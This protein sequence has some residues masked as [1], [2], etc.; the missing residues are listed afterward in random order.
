MRRITWFKNLRGDG[1][2]RFGVT[3]GEVRAPEPGVVRGEPMVLHLFRPGRDLSNPALRWFLDIE[4]EGDALPTQPEDVRGW[5]AARTDAM[6]AG[7]CG[8]AAELEPAGLD[9]GPFPLRRSLSGNGTECPMAVGIGAA[10][11][12]DAREVGRLL[13][14]TASELPHVLQSLQVRSADR[15]A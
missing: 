6:A 9:P 12:V 11:A 13:R 1:G 8:L 15:V 10:S 4:F 2:V 5:L 14:E 3:A 7:L